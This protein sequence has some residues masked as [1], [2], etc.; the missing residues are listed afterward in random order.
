MITSPFFQSRFLNTVFTPWVAFGTRTHSSTPAPIRFA[1]LSRQ[2]FQSGS[3]VNIINLSGLRSTSS[4]RVLLASE[5]GM[6][7]A[8]KEPKMPRDYRLSVRYGSRSR[9]SRPL[10]RLIYPGSN[11]KYSSNWCPNGGG[12]LSAY[13]ALRAGAGVSGDMSRVISSATNPIITRHGLSRASN[14]RRS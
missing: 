6:G 2:R 11:W 8:P 13:E 9:T 5:T 14:R 3:Y 10:F 7:M 1:T 12:C 4:A